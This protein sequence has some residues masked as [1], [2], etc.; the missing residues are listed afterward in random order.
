MRWS[1]R[2][3]SMFGSVI[4]GALAVAV[5]IQAQAQT[6]GGAGAPPQTPPGATGHAT[7]GASTYRITL[8]TGD[9]AELTI[10]ADGSRSGRLVD[11][12]NYYFGDFD[13]ELTVVPAAAYPLFTAGKLD[14][15]LFN[16]SLLAAQRYDDASTAKLPVL[17]S[18]SSAPAAP[19]GTT[20]RMTLASVGTTAVSIDKSEAKQFWQGIAGPRTLSSAS[21]VGKIWLDGRTH[22][23]LD[24]STAQIGAPIA[25]RSSYDGRG[26]KVAV[27]D[28]GYDAGHPDLQ[29]KVIGEASFVPD[30]AVQD[31]HGHGTH[32]A[33]TVAGLGKASGGKR[34]GVAPGAELLV[35]KVLDNNGG[36]LDSEAIA[37]MEW[38]VQQG[39]KVVSMSLGGLPSDGTDPMSEAVDRLSKSS[40]TLFVIAAGNAGTEESVG[41]P[42]TAAAAL[43]VG[44]VDRDDKLAPFSSRGPRLGDGALKPEV[45][46][47]GVEIVAARAAGTE[48]GHVVGEHY[49]AMSGTS[50][51]TPH[52]AGAAAIL[53]QRHPEWTGQQLKA[54][55]ATTA[56]PSKGTATAAQGLGRID[57]PRALDP[58]ILADTA[59]VY[60]GDVSWTGSAPKPVERKVAY[61]NTSGRAVT[62]DLSVEAKS[63]AGV[64]AS[65]AVTPRRLVVPAG[66]SAAATVRLDLAKTGPAKYAG[67]LVARVAGERGGAGGAEA[68]VTSYRTGL[69]FAAGGRLHQVTVQ[70]IGRDGKPARPT[71]AA[72]SGVQLWNLDTGDVNAVVFDDNG[73]RTLDVPTGRYAV[74]VYVMS[75]DQA[76]WVNGV[77]LLGAPEVTING[78]RTLVFDA[79]TAQPVTVKTPQRAE[80]ENFGIAWHRKVGDRE[81]VSGFGYDREVSGNVYV[82]DFGKVRDGSVRAVQ[83]WDLA[84]PKLTADVLGAGGFRLPTPRD[85]NDI[86]G[87][88]GAETLPL[89]NAGDGRPEELKDVR[90]KIALIRWRAYDQTFGQVEAAKAAGAKAVFLYNEQPGFWSDSAWVD[91]PLYL[92]RQPEGAKLLQ[93]LKQRPVQLKLTG[94]KD[95][96]YRYDLAVAPQQVK[97]AL[98]YDFAKLRPAVV[99]TNFPRVDA[100]VLHIDQRSAH[101]SGVSAG[102][103]ATRLVAGPVT[104]TD[105][106]ASDDPGTRW[107][108]KTSAGEWNE[109]GVEYSLARSYRPNERVNREVWAP[110]ARPAI[111]DA[112]GSEADGLP[113]ARFE[114]ALRIAIPQHVNGDR[115]IYG[116]SDMRGDETLL[117]LTSG[118]KELGRK[119][120]SVAQFAVPA[121]SAWY[122]LSLDVRR[123]P[124]TWATTSTA[125]QTEWR[126]R[127]GPV[128][129]REV[130]P[131]V[132]VDYKLS[133]RQLE[134]KPGYQPGARG[135]GFFRTTAEVSVDGKHWQP[136]RLRP[137]GWGL[138]A[139]GALGGRVAG[140]VPAGPVAA[141]RVT[142]TDLLGN[143]ITQTIEKPW[144]AK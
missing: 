18:G 136:L 88:V 33:S 120:W 37:G 126:F 71:V 117:R 108:E 116:W 26:V 58:K 103:G 12:S 127:S 97:G 40:G 24:R 31:G 144:P 27:L 123:A 83:R 73:Q 17:L 19:E 79:R 143:R 50:M 60:F 124:N 22:A 87:Y 135:L 121:K 35:G 74:M 15:R 104:R 25:W 99:T 2:A 113:V 102:L 30:Q 118:G 112:A 80:L 38:A 57:I 69:G 140:E 101:L 3:T 96:T 61:S 91:V 115:T 56:V 4:V 110:I 105:Y 44:A 20:R 141:L 137:G 28:T 95:S 59:N 9:V 107:D 48:Q 90:G 86:F 142:S 122:E 64:T 76:D 63:P 7:P 42:G 125:T 111:P 75:A 82:G 109:S 134:L 100:N 49:T 23:T 81:A 132:Q 14:R 32:V 66:G 36:G 6:T 85:G 54:A 98:T 93:L 34:K 119:D 128:R 84:Q 131:L 43:T 129:T 94:L 39:A 52:V 21:G 77:A 55:L 62:L 138:G 130:L 29:Q 70:G 47:P 53:A 72:N 10:S 5:P 106:L 65:L 46:A 133:G 13:G 78:D 8:V 139:S 11:G 89:V 45:T 51:A 1:R 67:E 68:G 92:L 114:N 16:L 41:T